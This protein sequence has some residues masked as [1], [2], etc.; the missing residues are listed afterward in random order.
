[1]GEAS[2]D[3]FKRRISR[4][5]N[6]SSLSRWMCVDIWTMRTYHLRRFK[7][8][9]FR[10]DVSYASFESTE[11]APCT[12]SKNS[13]KTTRRT[14]LPLR[15]R[16]KLRKRRILRKLYGTLFGARKRGDRGRRRLRHDDLRVVQ[17]RPPKR[18]PPAVQENVV[19]RKS[20]TIAKGK[21]VHQSCAKEMQKK[22]D[23][24]WHRYSN[25]ML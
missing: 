21:P 25:S 8:S 15:R 6:V 10:N 20:S 13:S 23:P 9:S 3:G 1:V 7:R 4:T 12:L 14:L 5:E 17:Q 2:R 24:M 16:Q 22:S 11:G 19:A 18:P